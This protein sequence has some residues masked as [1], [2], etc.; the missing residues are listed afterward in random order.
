MGSTAMNLHAIKENAHTAVRSDFVPYDW[1]RWERPIL[2]PI[3]SPITVASIL[4]G[5]NLTANNGDTIII[6]G[7]RGVIT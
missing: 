4:Q 7:Q 1:T 3:I 2:R 6:N 5:Y